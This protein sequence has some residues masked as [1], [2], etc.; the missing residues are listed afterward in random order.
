MTKRENLLNALRRQNPKYVPYSLVLCDAQ[1]EIFQA[2]TGSTDY[3]E[4][5]G[6]C[7][8]VIRL[9]ATKHPHDYSQFHPNLPQGAWIN[10]WGVGHAPGSVAHFSRMIHPMAH[11][12]TPDEVWA[13][14]T[15]DI[16]ADYRYVGVAESVKKYHSTGIATK[17]YAIQLFE[18]AWYW[19]G[20]DNFLCGMMQDDEMVHAMMEKMTA[21][22]EEQAK[23][24]AATGVDIIV[25]GD[26]VGT[27]RGM[28][29][30]LELWDKWVKPYTKRIIRAAKAVNPDVL[31]YYH[32][33]G[34]VEEIIPGLIDIG[35]DILN[36]VQP[37]CMCPA[38]IK[39]RYGDKLSFWGTVG[40]QTTMPFGTTAD[41]RRE[42]RARIDTVGCGGGFVIAPTHVIEP[43]VPW[44]NIVAFV[45]EARGYGAYATSQTSYP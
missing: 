25:F 16:T 31:A 27:Q 18:P 23:K 19:Y 15:P 37:E 7:H 28:M 12:T 33:D 17:F 45:E 41:V 6:A 26:D 29:M 21:L 34:A 35:V 4:Y 11:F 42:V 30:S 24:V 40:T 44:E 22:K 1:Q 10:D 43:E 38:K 5:F 13:F 20:L 8:R 32:T 9:D 39:A 14:P 2:K 36:P 3:L